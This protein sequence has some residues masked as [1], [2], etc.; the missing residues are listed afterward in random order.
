MGTLLNIQNILAFSVIAAMLIICL[1]MEKRSRKIE[2]DRS[3]RLKWEEGRKECEG[4]TTE[5][6][7]HEA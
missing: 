5:E 1:V 3:D 2:I 6:Q 7:S 4:K